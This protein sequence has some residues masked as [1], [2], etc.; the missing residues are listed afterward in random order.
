MLVLYHPFVFSITVDH[1]LLNLHIS[2]ENISILNFDL[3]FFQHILG[4]LKSF[5]I[6][7][8]IKV[9]L[10]TSIPVVEN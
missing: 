6:F 9:I 10:T 3:L 7:H 4:A 8:I 1:R 2:K 5:N